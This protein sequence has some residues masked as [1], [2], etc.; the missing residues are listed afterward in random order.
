MTDLSIA[1]AKAPPLKNWWAKYWRAV[2]PLLVALALAA[3]PA[4]A[5][6][7]PHAWIYF[8]IFA[9]VVAGL[10]L[11]PAPG[12]VVGLVGVT[13]VSVLSRWAWFSPA[14]LEKPGFD[15]A[16]AVVKWALSGFSNSTIWLI[17]GAFMF[18]LGYEKTG[19]G[20]RIALVIIRALGRRTLTLGYAIVVIETLLAPFIPSNTARTGGTLFPVIRC[21][22]PLYDSLPND[23]SA[24]RIGSYL[25]WTSISASCVASSL[26]LTAFAPNLLALEILKKTAKVDIGW[27]QWFLGFAPAGI[28][29]L[30]ILPL[31]VWLFYPPQVRQGGEV[32]RWASDQL[33]EL[34]AVSRRE[35]MFALL[36][37][38]GLGLWIFG[39]VVFNATTVVLIIICLMLVTGIV[40]WQ[41]ITEHRQAWNTLVWFAT[42]IAM[43]DGLNQTGF[44][45]W[46][47]GLIGSHLV[48]VSPIA[49]AVL[50]V[51]VFFFSHYLFA[52]G[53]AH[54]TAM[55]PVMLGVGAAIPGLPLE[56]L[57]LMLVLSLGIMG[58]ITPYGTGPS[59]IF[60]GSGYL[61]AKDYWRLGGIFGLIYFVTF[62]AIAMPILLLGVN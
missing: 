61:P 40:D 16:G 33:N 56:V 12:A 31:V 55:L 34:G 7:A 5:G 48:G 24:R 45:K 9:G 3:M 22:P 47:A 10:I 37:V 51:T 11:E 6:L 2:A 38:L 60:L 46:S 4:P 21:L 18:S 28:P 59:P 41:S 25:M 17:F 30:L 53:T 44:V 54:V 42:L 36:V 32:I 27:T 15:A 49:A 35:V 43:A 62:M 57:A 13:I 20:R 26:F 58:I 39:G 19:L 8:S 50:L 29:L 14:D 23:L 1:V 52:S